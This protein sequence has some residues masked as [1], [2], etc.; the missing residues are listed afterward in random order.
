[1]LHQNKIFLYV[2]L[3]KN[4]FIDIRKLKINQE[5]IIKKN[6]STGI[7][8]YIFNTFIPERVLFFIHQQ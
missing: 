8:I 6:I 3:I 5:K 4:N 7:I 2:S 1:M